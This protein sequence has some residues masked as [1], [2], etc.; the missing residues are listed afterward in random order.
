MLGGW[1]KGAESKR[2]CAQE[3][4]YCEQTIA[5]PAQCGT[6]LARALRRFALL[7]DA[8]RRIVNEPLVSPLP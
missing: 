3:V 5:W 7:R 1:G 4:R 6:W 2:S 8:K